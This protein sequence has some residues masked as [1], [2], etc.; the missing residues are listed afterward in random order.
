MDEDKVYEKFGKAVWKFYKTRQRPDDKRM[1]IPS[2]KEC[3]VYNNTDSD[4]QRNFTKKDL[5]LK[6]KTDCASGVPLNDLF[7]N[8]SI[9]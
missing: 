4:V 9:F 5:I 8:A 3:G 7:S 2:L 1:L 6:I